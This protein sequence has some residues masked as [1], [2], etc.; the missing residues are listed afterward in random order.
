MIKVGITGES[1][2]IGYH[3][4]QTLGLYSTKFELINF[5]RE[6]F[7]NIDKLKNFVE[8][9]DVI[10]H[11]A[12]IIRHKDSNLIETNNVE[13]VNRLLNACDLV[14]SKPKLFFASST[15][16][17]LNTPYGISKK[18]ASDIFKDWS[19]KNKSVT[20]ALIIPNV[21][22]PFCKPF[23][24]SVIATFCH[25]LV[26][27]QDPKIEIDKEL[28]LIFV[29]DL[30]EKIINCIYESFNDESK[31]FSFSKINIKHT[32]SKKVSEVL[33]KLKHF[34]ELY[35]DGGI[36]PSLSNSFDRDLFNSFLCYIDHNSFFP[37]GLDNNVDERG[38]F[39]ET[40]K[41]H[42]KGQVSFSS[43]APGITRGNH[44][45]TRK[46]ERFAVIKGK[47]QIDIRRIGTDKKISFFLDGAEPSFVDMPIWHTHKITN[48]GKNEL[49][50]LFWTNEYYDPEDSDT[51][52]DEV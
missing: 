39:V 8:S 24:N 12:S 1:G 51:Y 6:Y 48:I 34:K 13:L 29:N 2:F 50:T 30:S 37:Y 16:E 40:I 41:F 28:D 44:F 27:N 19:N 21:F 11:L 20:K 3:L 25:Q 5:K 31:E 15:Q 14:K 36:L 26:N 46:A 47:A 10:V 17:D 52:F 33:I 4:Y 18:M 43:T 42:S 49:Y 7:N 45:H 23:H 32:D 22:G 9:C 38:S 35:L